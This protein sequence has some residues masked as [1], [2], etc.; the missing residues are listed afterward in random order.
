MKRL[1][2]PIYITKEDLETK[3][4][5]ELIALRIR[6]LRSKNGLTQEELA[7]EADV[8]RSYIGQIERCEKN[9][10]VVTLQ[11]IAKSLGL[12]LYDFLTFDDLVKKSKYPSK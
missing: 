10:T 5:N 1:T 4:L 7:F 8:D 11:R 9:V 12:E 3:P 6:N 2:K